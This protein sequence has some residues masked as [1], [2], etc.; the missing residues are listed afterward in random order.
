MSITE[1]VRQNLPKIQREAFDFLLAKAYEEGAPAELK[2]A[3]ARWTAVEFK[4]IE[5]QK[6]FKDA[7]K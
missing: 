2:I 1:T 4:L 5:I 7:L 6:A 3:I